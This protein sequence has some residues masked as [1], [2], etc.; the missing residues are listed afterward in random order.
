MTERNPHWPPEP[1][2]HVA[3]RPPYGVQQPT[4]AVALR[5]VWRQVS[6]FR[7]RFIAPLGGETLMLTT[8]RWSAESLAK[9][10]GMEEWFGAWPPQLT[11]EEFDA[12][13]HLARERFGAPKHSSDKRRMRGDVE[14]EHHWH[15]PLA[16]VDELLE[17]LE[18]VAPCTVGS[19]AAPVFGRYG[20][21]FRLRNP[22]TGAVLR[23]QTKRNFHISSQIGVELRKR[24][25]ASLQLIIPFAEPD[26]KTADYVM[27]VQE[28]APVWI[29]PRYFDHL[30]P[31]PEGSEYLYR[32]RRLP[33]EWIGRTPTGELRLDASKSGIVPQ[34]L[35]LPTAEDL[36]SED[37]EADL[38]PYRK[39]FFAVFGALR[40][41]HAAAL[42][43]R[44]PGEAA[45]EFIVEQ[46]AQQLG[47]A[48]HKVS[49]LR[50]EKDAP[51]LDET[52][53]NLV[54]GL[55][56][57][58]AVMLVE[59]LPNVDRAISE[60]ILARMR[61]RTLVERAALPLAVRLV[62]IDY[63]F[64][65]EETQKA[66]EREWAARRE[67]FATREQLDYLDRREAAAAYRDVEV[68]PIPHAP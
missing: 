30:V 5:D 21:A 45:L 42:H 24:S 48:V 65:S 58:P 29:D 35:E 11:R 8:Q 47:M 68:I 12:A 55:E 51:S 61:T 34:K 27:A 25:T 36:A 7:E 38:G 41:H 32:R 39:N 13:V 44:G 66:G 18:M 2:A 17:Y 43:V 59:L 40:E 50:L 16:R 56:D 3:Y 15:L 19:R 22:K 10:P 46:S 28:H 63:T 60:A 4:R 1:R 57:Q 62:V 52:I 14:E 33:P 20:C 67:G 37:R 9:E 26:E 23:G 49:T 64:G 54:W 31:E 6:D 53:R